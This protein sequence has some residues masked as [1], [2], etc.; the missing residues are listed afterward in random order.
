MVGERLVCKLAA[1][2]NCQP[3]NSVNFS[4]SQ[5]VTYLHYYP[6]LL[7]TTDDDQEA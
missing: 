7:I 2:D 1:L 4:V 6:V 5:P 3:V